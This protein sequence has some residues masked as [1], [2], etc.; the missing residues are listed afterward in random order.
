MMTRRLNLLLFTCVCFFVCRPIAGEPLR[1]RP[2]IHLASAT[3]ILDPKLDGGVAKLRFCVFPGRYCLPM[4]AELVQ[5]TQVLGQIWN[6][7]VPTGCQA[8]QIVWDGKLNGWAVNT[9]HYSIRLRDTIGFVAP[10]EFPID[11]VRLGITEL[12][13]RESESGNDEWQMVYFMKGDDYAFFATPDIHEYLNKRESGEVSDLDHDDG[14]PRRPP[15]VHSETDSPVLE[16]NL[17]EDDRYNYPL[18]YLTNA[19]SRF[20]VTFGDSATSANGEPMSVGYPVD[21]FEIRVSVYKARTRLSSSGPIT[22]G[23]YAELNGPQMPAMV[24]RID[25]ELE[26]RWEYRRKGGRV[27]SKIPGSTTIPLRFYTVIGKP[28]FKAGAAGLQY[29]GPWVEV[30]EY[31]DHWRTELGIDTSTEAG[32][33]RNHV[34]GFFGQVESLPQAIEGVIYNAPRYGG[35]A[36][37]GPR[38]FDTT[39]TVKLA[40]LL[41]HHDNDRYIN[42]FDNMGATSTMLSMMGVRNVKSVRLVGKRIDLHSIWPIGAGG[43]TTNLF[44]DGHSFSQHALVT[45]DNAIRIID[46]TMQVDADEDRTHI[47]GKR[48]WNHDRR[49]SGTD[50]YDELSSSSQLAT[51]LVGELP[52]LE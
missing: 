44:S 38:Y 43:Y 49:I 15:A 47:P 31:W 4:T 6:G 32:C 46:T 50:G 5:G 34:R 9:G 7:R 12:A 28:Q 22:P 16:G 20:E 29:S 35:S 51:P 17:Y 25:H 40:A 10:V 26:F 36:G 14:T 41:N 11:V 23:G 19:R 2:Q 42:C 45:R 37:A 52:E 33:V 48:G 3:R 13:A 24:R 30:A 21:G 39:Y 18:C 8:R 1:K 27:W